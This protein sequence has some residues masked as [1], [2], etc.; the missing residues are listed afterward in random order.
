MTVRTGWYGTSLLQTP[1]ACTSTPCSIECITQISMCKTGGGVN[2]K[3]GAFPEA[4]YRGKDYV[5]SDRQ[6]PVTSLALVATLAHNLC[7]LIHHSQH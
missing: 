7:V 2:F 6:V 5:D 1:S 4:E 3:S